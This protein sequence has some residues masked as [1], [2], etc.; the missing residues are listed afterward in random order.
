MKVGSE[1]RR[2]CVKSGMSMC[3]NCALPVPPCGFVC[4][5]KEKEE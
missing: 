2:G 4:P 1:A 5:V 3:V